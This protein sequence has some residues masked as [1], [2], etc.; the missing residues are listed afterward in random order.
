[1]ALTVEMVTFDTTD[2]VAL[3]TW[4]ARQLGG[5]VRDEADG[6]FVVAVDVTGVAR[7]GFQKVD[8]VTPGKN[9][10]HLDL[11]AQ[12]ARAEV[13]R[14]VADGATYVDTHTEGGFTWTVLADPDGN[15]FC[16]SQS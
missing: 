9:R 2:A 16:V 8:A 1:M 13:D 15:Q 7:V 10:V 3:A 4:W 5:E 6:W 12:D 11:S 14:L